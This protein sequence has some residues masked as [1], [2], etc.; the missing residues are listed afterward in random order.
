MTP[1]QLKTAH[2]LWKR[3]KTQTREY[4]ELAASLGIQI[5]DLNVECSRANAIWKQTGKIT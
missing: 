5:T 2:R 1:Q 3:Y 4:R